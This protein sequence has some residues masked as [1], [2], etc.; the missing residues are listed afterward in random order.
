MKVIRKGYIQEI[1]KRWNRQ[2]FMFNWMQLGRE[3]ITIKN[4]FEFL[5]WET[6]L[7]KLAKIGEQEDNELFRTR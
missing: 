1:S 6:S 3:N 2:E 4:T 7:R 5:E